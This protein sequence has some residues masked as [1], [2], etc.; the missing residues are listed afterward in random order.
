MA[1][2]ELDADWVELDVHALADGGLVVHHDPELPDGRAL[3]DLVTAEL[4]QWVPLLDAVLVAC[5][6][7]GV[8]VEIK[9]DGPLPLRPALVADTIA[10]LERSGD[11][12]RFLITSFEPSILDAVR[13]SAPQ[14]RTGVLTMDDPMVDG[15]LDG[16]AAAGHC[17]I[18]PWNG[19]VTAAMVTAAHARGLEVNVWTVDDPVRIRELAAFGVD[20]II[21]NVPDLCRSALSEG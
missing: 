15:L 3:H 18:N 6:P 19:R 13:A 14:L 17:A 11:T 8:N 20:G 21:T 10:L 2:R 7:M 9:A 5:G 1:A 4:P 16:I 12:D